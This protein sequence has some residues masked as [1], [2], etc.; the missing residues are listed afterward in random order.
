M[1]AEPLYALP[2][3]QPGADRLAEG[4]IRQVARN[5]PCEA[6]FVGS[7]VAIQAT[8]NFGLLA[9]SARKLG[10]H[11]PE[12]SIVGFGRLSGVCYYPGLARSPEHVLG[13]SYRRERGMAGAWG[14]TFTHVKTVTPIELP[15][16][17]EESGCY[18]PG[19]ER[20]IW[21]WTDNGSGDWWGC[22]LREL[23]RAMVSCVR[24]ARGKG[25]V[26]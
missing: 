7:W 8:T 10:G 17:G 2:V 19:L 5:F 13:K 11:R 26:E 25:R 16:Y 15:R 3:R 4:K 18:D 24:E 20:R 14:W 22:C 23:D 9:P 1:A 12:W 21:E 6:R